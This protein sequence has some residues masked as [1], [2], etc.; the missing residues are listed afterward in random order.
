[1]KSWGRLMFFVVPVAGAL[2]VGGL[3]VAT[4]QDGQRVVPIDK[5]VL[6]NRLRTAVT[7]YLLPDLGTYDLA[8]GTAEEFAWAIVK[9][10]ALSA[11]GAK[12]KAECGKRYA[13]RS[14]GGSSTIVEVVLNSD[15]P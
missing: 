7:M 11:D 15:R 12:F 8:G 1:M 4:A 3:S 6:S 10:F 5:V 14:Q 2:T 13:V 9:G